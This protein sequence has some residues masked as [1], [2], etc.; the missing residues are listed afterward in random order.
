M[1]N[2]SHDKP[3]GKVQQG[4]QPSSGQRSDPNR[5]PGDQDL[6]NEDT[7]GN[8]FYDKN[9][10]IKRESE[11]HDSTAAPIGKPPKVN[12]DTDEFGKKK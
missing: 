4:S 8:V 12:Q 7:E 11:F 6:F 5:E 1:S 3:G 9:T 2:S 10:E